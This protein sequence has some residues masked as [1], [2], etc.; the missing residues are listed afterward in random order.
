MDNGKTIHEVVLHYGPLR[1]A[2]AKHAIEEELEIF[3]N[4]NGIYVMTRL[5][6][7]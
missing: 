1:S 2:G 4:T 6:L 7:I 5:K 3:W